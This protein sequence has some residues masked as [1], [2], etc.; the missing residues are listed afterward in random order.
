MVL[1]AGTFDVG[2]VGDGPTRSYRAKVDASFE[3][4]GSGR[5]F[6]VEV[7]VFVPASPGSTFDVMKQHAVDA[8]VPVLEAAVAL[9]RSKTAADMKEEQWRQEE[10]DSA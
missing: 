7:S 6:H 1:N 8:A 9:L 5:R 4:V 3:E 10:A 2:I